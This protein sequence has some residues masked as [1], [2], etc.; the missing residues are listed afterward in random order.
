MGYVPL[1]TLGLE[2]NLLRVLT[3]DT[4]EDSG[5]SGVSTYEL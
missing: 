2:G 5:I 1:G 3:L 4:S